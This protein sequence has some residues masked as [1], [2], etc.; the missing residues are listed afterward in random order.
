MLEACCNHDLYSMVYATIGFPT[1]CP[2]ATSPSELL[3]IYYGWI[4]RMVTWIERKT[5]TMEK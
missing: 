4:L 2:I 3:I 1:E 5:M